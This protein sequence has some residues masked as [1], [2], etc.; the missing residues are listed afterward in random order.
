M[1]TFWKDLNWKDVA[2]II[3]PII[4]ILLGWLLN[5][6]SQLVKLRREDK[7]QLGKVITE[8]LEI[9]H[10]TNVLKQVS[11]LMKKEFDLPKDMHLQVNH[12]LGSVILNLANRQKQY[13]D[14]VNSIALADPVLA[15][16][17]RSQDQAMPFFHHMRNVMLG[18]PKVT[19]EMTEWVQLFG[20][21]FNE[22]LTGKINRQILGL[23]RKHGW[24]TWLRARKFLNRTDEIPADLTGLINEL[25]RIVEKDMTIKQQTVTNP[26]IDQMKGESGNS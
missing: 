24:G 25:K 9:Y 20:D 12:F 19:T 2:A 22:M 6:A 13:E 21:K 15:F 10:A 3:G 23:S 4:G 7:R 14:A 16:K 1:N 17:L 26:D 5:E 18:D 8:L 11:T